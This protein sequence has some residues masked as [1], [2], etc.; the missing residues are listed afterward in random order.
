VLEVLQKTKNLFKVERFDSAVYELKVRVKKY[1]TALVFCL[2]V[3][4]TTR[5]VSS[6]EE[7]KIDLFD[8]S[9]EISLFQDLELIDK[10]NRELSDELPFFYNYSLVGGYFNMPSARSPKTGVIGIGCARVTPYDVYGVNYQ[11]FNRIELSANYRIYNGVIEGHFGH[12]GFGDDAERIGNI[13]IGVLIPE[14][15]FPMLPQIA[16]GADDFMGTKRF[17]A[18]Y[19]VATK[20]I[21][22]WN[23][24]LTLGWGKKRFKGFFGGFAWTPFRKTHLPVLKNL[25]VVAEYDSINYKKHE[26]EHPN[27]RKVKSQVNAGLTYVG[28]DTLQLSVS[29][30]RGTEIAASA[31]LRYPLGSTE[32]LFPKIDD[33]KKYVSPVDSEPLGIHRP[34]EELAHELAY[35]FSDQGL[36]LYSAYITYDGNQNKVLWLKVVNNRYR[37]EKVVRDRIIHVI[38]ALTPSDVKTVLVVVEADAVPCQAYQFRTEDLERWRKNWISDF[39]LDTLAPMREAPHHPSEYDSVKI[40]QRHKPIWSFT[41]LPRFQSFF[42]SA[43]GKFKYNLSAVVSPEGYIF[44]EVFYR[45]QFSY[46]FWSSMHG[47]GGP[48]RNNPSKLPN[49]RTDTLLYF[50]ENSFSM[51]Q[52]YL[53]KSWNLG[54]G[55]FTRVAT[56]YFEP[57]YGGGSLEF[58]WY[59]VDSNLAIGVEFATVMKRHYHGVKFTN[60]VR[61]FHDGQLR[62]VPF[63][64]IQC[65]LDLYYDFKPL[66]MDVLVSAGRFLARDVGVRTEVGRYFKSGVR[67]A[68]WYTVTNGHDHVN[69]STY[70]DKGFIF[71]APL[72]LFMKQSSRTYIGYSMSAWLRDVGARAHTGKPLY[73]TLEEERYN[74]H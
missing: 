28:W 9:K 7:P 41:I 58:L 65:F 23:L 6:Q 64:G 47:L 67:F 70:H 69:G 26:H 55:F 72:D 71:S 20:Q 49:V 39:S 51:E 68:L 12:E 36:D 2:A 53:Q 17:N 42:G 34:K 30:V 45:F 11:V 44:D 52:A 35:A 59:P 16:V 74:Y 29:S 18:Q 40:F 24:E 57:A 66:N 37:Q 5:G 14:D 33:P 60:K 10:I 15:G 43:S 62:Y 1:F 13:K 25:S 54:K 22:D 63:V 50:Q 21:L 73:W 61:E 19:I 48:D 4:L 56:G 3:A 32:G 8:Q 46:A 31:S 38:A 27:G